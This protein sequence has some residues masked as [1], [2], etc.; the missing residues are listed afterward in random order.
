MTVGQKL[1]MTLAQAES[2]A[3]N[4]KSFSLDTQDQAAK[5]LFSQLAKTM[6]DHIIA[7]LKARVNKVEA[8]EPTY[9][10]YPGKK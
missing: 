4:L 9:K 3:A 7:P 5:Q 6:E 8:E 1:H 10:A 2:V